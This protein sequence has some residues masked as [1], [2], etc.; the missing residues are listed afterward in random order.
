[1][2]A[3][4]SKVR[5]SLIGTMAYV[6]IYIAG[7]TAYDVSWLID[8]LPAYL[9]P[10]GE[11][12][13]TEWLVAGVSLGGGSAWTVLKNGSFVTYSLGIMVNK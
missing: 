4:L 2:Y 8:F 13:I 9:Y 1:M 10:R 7:G 3:I 6:A 12:K 5:I 11:R